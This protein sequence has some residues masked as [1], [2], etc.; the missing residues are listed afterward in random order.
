MFPF[1]SGLQGVSRSIV[2]V[3]VTASILGAS[4]ANAAERIVTVTERSLLRPVPGGLL[5]A[6]AVAS[7]ASGYALEPQIVAAAN[8]AILKGVLLRRAGA[9]RTVLFFGPNVFTVERG[10]AIAQILAPFDVNIMMMDYRGYG[11]S[12]GTPSIAAFMTDGEAIFDHLASLP[13]IGSRSIV[14]HGHSIG[15]FVAGH[16]AA[17]R[18]TGGVV[19]Q[20]SATAA[21]DFVKGQIPPAL[22]D[23]VKIVVEDSLKSQG[24]LQNMDKL[25]EPLL[26]IVGA[27]DKVTVPSMS[28]AL[29]KASTLPEKR[30]HLAIIARAGHNDVFSQPAALDAYRSFLESIR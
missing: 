7:V 3:V 17:V 27:S 16:V 2:S 6:E 10:V 21:E 20:S 19:L 4:P 26:I 28:E 15:S 5:T 24:N 9:T 25:D 29:Y 12:G 14:V 1:V 23:S 18:P 11:A 30:K 13:G 8:G 22:Q